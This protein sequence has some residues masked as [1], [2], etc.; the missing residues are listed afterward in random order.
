MIVGS[1]SIPLT[2]GPRGPKYVDL[3]DPDPEHWKM[4]AF[5]LRLNMRGVCVMLQNST[6]SRV[7]YGFLLLVTVV[8][9]CIMLAPGVQVTQLIYSIFFFL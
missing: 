1:G 6:A 8:I 3:L 5:C 7:M 2:N 9:S 4:S